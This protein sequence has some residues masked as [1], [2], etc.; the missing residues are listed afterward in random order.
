MRLHYTNN[1]KVWDDTN[2]I[3]KQFQ[4]FCRAYPRV[5]TGYAIDLTEYRLC[6][7]PGTPEAQQISHNK[8]WNNNSIN[9]NI[10]DK[11]DVNMH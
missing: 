1:K 5:I 3:F 2:I 10:I 11:I 4:T 9:N 8:Q 6:T 7:H